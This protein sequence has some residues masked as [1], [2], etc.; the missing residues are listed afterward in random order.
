MANP[1]SQCFSVHSTCLICADSLTGQE[2]FSLHEEVTDS[3]GKMLSDGE[4]HPF[5]PNCLSQWLEFSKP[6]GTK[7]GQSFKVLCP[8]CRHETSVTSKKMAELAAAVLKTSSEPNRDKSVRMDTDGLA[9]RAKRSGSSLSLNSG[10]NKKNHFSSPVEKGSSASSAS[11]S[12]F[13]SSAASSSAFSSKLGSTSPEPSLT[14]LVKDLLPKVSYRSDPSL[15]WGKMIED[16]FVRQ[17]FLTGLSLALWE[18]GEN[19]TQLAEK[20]EDLRLRDLVL[21]KPNTPL[22]RRMLES[23]QKGSH[24][25]HY[26][27]RPSSWAEAVDEMITRLN[28]GM[29]LFELCT[30]QIIAILTQSPELPHLRA[31]A[32]SAHRHCWRPEAWDIIAKH[33][34]FQTLDL[35][36]RALP[37]NTRVLETLAKNNP[38]LEFL[39]L[40]RSGLRPSPEISRLIEQALFAFADH[41][42]RLK[43]LVIGDLMTDKARARFAKNCPSL[44]IL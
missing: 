11:S 1:I 3:E 28:S 30:N 15:P 10:P 35:S 16:P 26:S 2:P 23:F 5:H 20:I 9:S 25:S 19:A 24:G 14:Q 21:T 34:H 17:D 33:K 7:L 37:K 18:K 12:S 44:K 40:S 36:E 29:T 27:C 22:G 42:P 31:P 43:T 39:N 6:G 13:S 38:G 41:C 32:T 4:K 8:G